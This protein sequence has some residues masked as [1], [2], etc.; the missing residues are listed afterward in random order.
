MN[1]DAQGKCY[2]STC[3]QGYCWPAG[4]LWAGI[5]WGGSLGVKHWGLC[6]FLLLVYLSFIVLS[7]SS[8]ADLH[9]SNGMRHCCRYTCLKHYPL[10]P[11]L[12]E[13]SCAST[14]SSPSPLI[15][16]SGS[17]AY[18]PHH[19]PC[20]PPHVLSLFSNLALTLPLC[21]LLSAPP[22]SHPHVVRN[23]LQMQMF[24]LL[25]NVHCISR[26]LYQADICISK[27]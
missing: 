11:P 3:V 19:L 23:V 17:F 10:L 2:H 22:P 18:S 9:S 14:L 4:G 12:L 25:R 5:G 7:L 20:P 13:L 27:W 24:F 1:P 6:L 26:R 21:S 8:L 15:S 16:L